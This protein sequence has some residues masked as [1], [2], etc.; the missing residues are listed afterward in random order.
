M[1]I[2]FDVSGVDHQKT[3]EGQVQL[4][5]PPKGMYTCVLKS[6]ENVDKK[7]GDGKQLKA[8]YVVVQD[9]HKN[10]PFYD[11]WDPKEESQKW[12]MDQFLYAMGIDTGTSGPTGKF[13]TAKH[14]MKTK[15]RVR[16]KHD[17]YVDS[18]GNT[19]PSAKCGGVFPFD[20]TK[21]E[22]AFPQGDGASTGV[23]VDWYTLGEEADA[24]ADNTEAAAALTAKAEEFGIDVMQIQTWVE[25]AE[26]IQ[27]AVSNAAVEAAEAEEEAPPAK[28]AAGKKAAAPAKAAAKKAPPA[29]AK[30]AAKTTKASKKAAAAPEPE[31]E[32]EEPVEW[33]ELGLLAEADDTDSQEFL[34]TKAV[35]HDLDPDD[36]SWEELAAA[37]AAKEAGTKE[38][39]DYEN[40]TDEAL[41][42]ELE[43]RG[44]KTTGT[45][46][47]WILRLQK[48]DGEP[49]FQE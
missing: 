28:K 38:A 37:I 39:P 14:V 30:A 7:S 46:K 22:E 15:V 25:V 17:T 29:P 47:V 27:T 8:T 20:P 48:S 49:L 5:L 34:N 12:K 31:P 6:L 1:Q 43:S 33:D 13:D 3:V 45:R 36:F 18:D 42:A 40:M 23:A 11:Y 24:D 35:E 2:A 19:I 10:F 32:S 26:E 16:C 9:A 44:L 4:A 41:G 21:D